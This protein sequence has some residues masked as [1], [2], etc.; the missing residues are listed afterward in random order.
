MI[1]KCP[2]CG[3]MCND[4]EIEIERVF[5]FRIMKGE[6]RRQSYCRKCRRNG[7]RTPKPAPATTPAPDRPLTVMDFVDRIRKLKAWEGAD[8]S[9]VTITLR[10]TQY[11]YSSGWARAL[12]NKILLRAGTR[13]ED[14][15]IT[16]IHEFAHHVIFIKAWKLRTESIAECNGRIVLEHP[17]Y[18]LYKE[19]WHRSHGPA[20]QSYER[21]AY[22]EWIGERVIITDADLKHWN[23]K[24]GYHRYALSTAA[25]RQLRAKMERE[26]QAATPLQE[27]A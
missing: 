19:L 6:R 14:A 3:W 26:A 21:A 2:K 7:N 25:T 10:N 16:L 20:F 11:A 17:K 27:A 5:G 4:D 8:L 13:L 23:A 22:E 24:R 15:I 18:K 1:N 9:R 12:G